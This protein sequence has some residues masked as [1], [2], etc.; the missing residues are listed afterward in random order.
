MK[1]ADLTMETIVVVALVLIVMVVS[2]LI[3]TNF[4]IKIPQGTKCESQKDATCEAGKACPIGSVPA[5]GLTCG[6]DEICC[7]KMTG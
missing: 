6:T 1:K 7:K 2:Y 5:L 3:Y 4:V